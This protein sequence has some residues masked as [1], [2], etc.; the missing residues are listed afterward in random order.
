MTNLHYDYSDVRE[1]VET[2]TKVHW[3]EVLIRASDSR[4]K[5]I[6]LTQSQVKEIVLLHIDISLQQ[7]NPKNFRVVDRI[8]IAAHFL[9]GGSLER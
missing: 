4:F 8:K 6:G 2:E 7:F 5:Q 1:L 3:D 9:F